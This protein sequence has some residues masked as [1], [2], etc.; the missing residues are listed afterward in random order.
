VSQ[1]PVSYIRLRKN[2]GPG[3]A[4][5]AGV[6]RAR[7]EVIVFFDADVVLEKGTL[8]HIRDRFK[9]EAD[10]VALTGVWDKQQKSEAFFPNFKA[11]RDWSYWMQERN[12]GLYYLFSPR[13][14]AIRRKV[15]KEMVGFKTNYKGADVEDIELT[16]RIAAKYQIEFDPKARVRH[17]FGGF[18]SIARDYFR[19]SYFW[20]PLF[21]RRWKF[22]PVATTGQ[23][24][25]AGITAGLCL[26]LRGRALL[27]VGLV[28]LYLV[29]RFIRFV[30]QERGAVMAMK[31]LVAGYLFY[32]VILAGVGWY[33]VLFP[34]R[35]LRK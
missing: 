23:E 18:R 15:F 5:N 29:R 24:A 17:E 2:I 9:Q 12:G 27:I 16:Y 10:L 26:I 25:L 20:T 33:L 22:D 34:F 21:L 14:A 19:R 1:W 6:K 31:A 8:K 13:V 28:H 4:R 30:W 3:G 35:M 11:L 7:G 32:L